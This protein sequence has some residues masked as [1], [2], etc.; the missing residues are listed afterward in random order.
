MGFH[1]YIAS[2]DASA[3][4][5]E[6]Y[7]VEDKVY[8]APSVRHPSLAEACI[9]VKVLLVK[10][11]ELKKMNAFIFFVSVAETLAAVPS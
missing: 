3:Q 8:R 10:L 11:A 2:L 6:G 9:E 7:H 4:N 1:F 5:F